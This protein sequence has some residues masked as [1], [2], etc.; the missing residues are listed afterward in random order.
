ML[1]CGLALPA[2]GALQWNSY[3][4]TGTLI[5]ANV[6]TGGDLASGHECDVYHT[7]GCH[8]FFCHQKLSADCF[9]AVNGAANVTFKFSA[10]GGLTGGGAGLG[11]MGDVQL[12][13]DGQFGG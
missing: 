8:Q 2:F 3:D 4:A 6:A 7:R 5:T 10:S 12:A 1:V 13:G 11:A 9:D